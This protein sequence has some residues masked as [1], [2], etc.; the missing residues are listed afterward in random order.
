ML[1]SPGWFL[2]FEVCS[3]RGRDAPGFSASAGRFW[4]P[5]ASG[6]GLQVLRGLLDERFDVARRSGACRSRDFA[7]TGKDGERGNRL[8]PVPL[9]QI[10]QDIRVDFD[11]EHAAGL[12]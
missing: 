4:S 12:T 10:A 6:S 11:D 8:D 9:S 3:S 5:W 1:A 2:K 7:A